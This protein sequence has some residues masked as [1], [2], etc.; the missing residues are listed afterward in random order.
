MSSVKD[1]IHHPSHLVQKPGNVV[2]K[3]PKS[4]AGLVLAAAIGIIG[5]YYILP[6]LQRYMKI[7]RM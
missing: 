4:S 3:H 6:E 2:I 7:E 1:L 5:L